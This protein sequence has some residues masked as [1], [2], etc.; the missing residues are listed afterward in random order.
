MEYIIRH[1]DVLLIKMPDEFEVAFNQDL[2]K[3]E[4]TGS[5][6]KDPINNRTR[7]LA[8]FCN[9]NH[10]K[11]CYLP[12]SRLRSLYTTLYEH[13]PIPIKLYNECVNSKESVHITEI[14]GKCPFCDIQFITKNDYTYCPNCFFETN[15]INAFDN[16]SNGVE[17]YRPIYMYKRVNHYINK[18]DK[19]LA[20]EKISIPQSVINL[21]QRELAHERTDLITPERIHTILSRNRMTKYTENAYQIYKIITNKTYITMPPLIR[22]A[23]IRTFIEVDQALNTILNNAD[24]PPASRF[25]NYNYLHYKICEH[26]GYKK[27]QNVFMLCKS[28]DK[29]IAHDII[30]KKICQELGWKFIPTV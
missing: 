5:S 7:M 1:L 6:W 22:S 10:D 9:Y 12:S 13:K 21:V 20:C 24:D 2:K 18:L 11:D 30:W 23:L 15:N 14:Y 4:Q 29:I 19:L 17:K 25:L 28:Q 26:L 8:L 3:L 16:S 27:Y